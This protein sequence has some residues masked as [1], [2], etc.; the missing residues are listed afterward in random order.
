[1]FV[2]TDSFLIVLL[3]VY[4]LFKYQPKNLNLVNLLKEFKASIEATHVCWGK[5]SESEIMKITG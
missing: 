3:N 5:K 4:D 1:M 2:F